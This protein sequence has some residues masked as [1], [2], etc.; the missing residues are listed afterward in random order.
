MMRS[1]MNALGAKRLLSADS[2][3]IDSG[4]MLGV[5]QSVKRRG[6]FRVYSGV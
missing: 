1:V 6:L 4:G 3:G 2:A 5:Y